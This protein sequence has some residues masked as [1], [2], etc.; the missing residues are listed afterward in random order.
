ML[1]SSPAVASDAVYVGGQYGKVYALNAGSRAARH[2][3]ASSALRCLR[4]RAMLLVSD[5]AL[6]RTCPGAQRSLVPPEDG[7]FDHA[8]GVLTAA[9]TGLAWQATTSLRDRSPPWRYVTVS[10]PVRL[11]AVIRSSF[12]RSQWSPLDRQRQRCPGTSTQVTAAAS[13]ISPSTRPFAGCPGG[14]SLRRCSGPW[15][16]TFRPHGDHV[17]GFAFSVHAP[18][19]T[20]GAGNT[21]FCRW[22]ASMPA[23]AYRFLGQAYRGGSGHPPGFIAQ[24]RRSGSSVL[25]SCRWV[26]GQCAGCVL[27]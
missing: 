20:R 9:W 5:S 2:Q 8:A 24:D 11:G 25:T 26:P 4:P 18:V 23:T 16:L 10:P 7:T 22:V 15:Q 6:D 3:N 14:V 12:A 21:P 1:N 13:H 17:T 19:S 27:G